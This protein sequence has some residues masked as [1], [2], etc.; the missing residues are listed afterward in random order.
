MIAQN[1]EKIDFHL[2]NAKVENKNFWLHQ[3]LRFQD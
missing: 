3:I 1:D 2:S